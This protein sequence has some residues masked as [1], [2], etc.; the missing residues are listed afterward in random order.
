MDKEDLLDSGEKFFEN[1]DYQSALLVF[2]EANTLEETDFLQNYIGCCYLELNQHLEAI[3]VF[4]RIMNTNT[5]WE[6]PVMNLAR[7]FFELGGEKEAFRLLRRARLL[8][9]TSEDVY[10][11]SGVFYMKLHKYKS[12]IGSFKKSLDLNDTE[13][14]THLNLGLCYARTKRHHEA[15][16]E[17]KKAYQL[18]PSC[19][20][21]LFNA[22]LTHMHLKEYEMAFLLFQKLQNLNFDEDLTLD[23]IQCLLKLKRLDEA[24]H[25]WSQLPAEHPEKSKLESEIKNG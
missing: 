8:C 19:K 13:S 3:K 5:T 15:M 11:Y 12:A 7:V 18:E 9:P 14:D 24:Y 20:D 21:A 25:Y 2:D 1:G 10:F 4:I 6:R 22:A 17:F 23:M 16:D